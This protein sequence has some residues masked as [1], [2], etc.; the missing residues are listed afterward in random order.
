[1]V[2]SNALTAVSTKWCSKLCEKCETSHKRPGGKCDIPHITK[3]T[4]AHF[5]LEFENPF[6][7]EF[8]S[9]FFLEFESPIFL[10]F[11]TPIG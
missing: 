6:F 2:R 9:P 11:V 3:V 8:E 5:F 1:M 4:K 10:K 7:L